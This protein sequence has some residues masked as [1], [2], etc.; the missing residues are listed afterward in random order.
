MEVLSF[1]ASYQ[2]CDVY[3]I[4]CLLVTVQ[5]HAAAYGYHKKQ[6]AILQTTQDTPQSDYNFRA[7]LRQAT[8]KAAI[9]KTDFPRNGIWTLT[10]QLLS[11]HP[12]D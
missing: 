11:R 3:A 10:S 9:L 8:T 5:I 1:L 2:I 4:V 6:S 12:I 7:K